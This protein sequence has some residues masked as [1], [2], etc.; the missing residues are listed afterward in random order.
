VR[1][2]EDIAAPWAPYTVMFSRD[3]TRL[4]IGGGSWYGLGGIALFD[5]ATHAIHMAPL[6]EFLDQRNARIEGTV[7]GLAFSADDRHLV[8][9]TWTSSQRSGPTIAFEVDGL[10]LTKRVLRERRG[11]NPSTG[12]VSLGR[13]AI[14]RVHGAQLEEAIEIHQWPDW[15]DIDRA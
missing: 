5:L 9:S 8:A 14:V 1:L 6:A 12:I 4:A 13:N 11:W 3:G 10:A 2:I 15:L 7:S